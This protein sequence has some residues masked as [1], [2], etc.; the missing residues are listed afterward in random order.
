MKTVVGGRW[1]V[2][3]SPEA[4]PILLLM[5]VCLLPSCSVPNLEPTEC[6][7]A[8]ESVREFYSFHFGNDMHPSPENIR[9]RERFL[10][11][12]YASSLRLDAGA[13]P[14]TNIDYFTLTEDLPKTF[15]VGECT[16]V[17]PGRSTEFE[18]L[19]FWKDDTRTEQREIV[20]GARYENNDWLIDRVSPKN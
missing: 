9:K 13:L 2:V 5:V 20:A 8:R 15:R 6:I 14:P 10:T 4:V 17:E 7:Q 3:G 12:Q 11:Q 1:L 18:V 16:V 19:L